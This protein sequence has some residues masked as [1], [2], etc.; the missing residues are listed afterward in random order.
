M[1]VSFV[2]DLESLG[3]RGIVCWWVYLLLLL[4]LI[5]SF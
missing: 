1:I 4:S 5:L 2:F 3:I